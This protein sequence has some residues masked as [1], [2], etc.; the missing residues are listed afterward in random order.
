MKKI[1][2]MLA[3]ALVAV[4]MFAQSLP[5]FSDAENAYVFDAKAL[6][7]EYG[8]YC[9]VVNLSTE[10]DLAFDV[11]LMKSN[12]KEWVLA[13]TA[14]LN[15]ILDTVTLKSD[16][17]GKFG[18]YRYFALVPHDTR[19]Y[20]VEFNYDEI[21]MYVVEH[22]Y[23]AFIVDTI[24]DTAEEIRNNSTIIDVNSISGKFKD[25]IK[26]ENKS[27]DEKIEIIV[28]GFDNAD[29]VK[30]ECVGKAV[31]EGANDTDQLETVLHDHDVKKFAYYGIYCTNGKKY[32][33]KATKAHSD[34][35]IQML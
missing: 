11:Y 23:S 22:H 35:Q 5:V 2:A 4:S 16:Y 9:K 14:I 12:K 30:W 21:D 34:L 32:E 10:K 27:A 20:K 29:S 3:T 8:D 25:N 17:N 33:V 31:L 19:E 26:F 7:E 24:D 1:I 18:R 6:K 28:Y 15:G 13:G